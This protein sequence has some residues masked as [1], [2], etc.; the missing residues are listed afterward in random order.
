M[1]NYVEWQ[2]FWEHLKNIS[3]PTLY[4]FTWSS[5]PI[6]STVL[7]LV[8]GKTD[9]YSTPAFHRLPRPQRLQARRRPRPR[10]ATEATPPFCKQTYKLIAKYKVEHMERTPR[11]I[12][13]FCYLK[14]YFLLI[15]GSW[16]TLDGEL[17]FVENV[18]C[19]KPSTGVE[20]M[21]NNTAETR[22][23]PVP[24]RVCLSILITGL[25]CKFF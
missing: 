16:L 6:C 9:L 14:L 22:T 15:L 7:L 25:T 3:S 5:P 18:V 23:I 12:I 8:P 4:V 21:N 10:P 24:T 13:S 11:F 17:C 20:N 1:T 19:R 2:F